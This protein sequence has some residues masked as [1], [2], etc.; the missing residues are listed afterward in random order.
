MPEKIKIQRYIEN[1]STNPRWGQDPSQIE[2]TVFHSRVSCQDCE[3]FLITSRIVRD[4]DPESLY[5]KLIFRDVSLKQWRL[6][7]T[8]IVSI[9]EGV[10][11][12]LS[13]GEMIILNNN[14]ED[15]TKEILPVGRH[16]SS[17]LLANLRIQYQLQKFT[18]A[19]FKFVDDRLTFTSSYEVS[20]RQDDEAKGFFDK[21]DTYLSSCDRYSV[22]SSLA[23][24]SVV[25]GAIYLASRRLRPRL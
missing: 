19:E 21:I 7:L 13:N 11:K 5:Y 23:I 2:F 22:A 24:T 16:Q 15:S 12:V 6:Q 4:E 1:M 17:V 8:P 25:G 10:L 9:K 14:F 3:N 20:E 18:D